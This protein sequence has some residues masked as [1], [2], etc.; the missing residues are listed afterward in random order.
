MHLIT[1]FNQATAIL[2][3]SYLIWQ[4][5]EINLASTQ[6]AI[7]AGCINFEMYEMKTADAEVV[8]SKRPFNIKKLLVCT[9]L[10]NGSIFSYTQLRQTISHYHT[11]LS[12]F[13]STNSLTKHT[14]IRRLYNLRP[15]RNNRFVISQ[16]LQNFFQ[17]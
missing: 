11:K 14:T 4:K 13:I 12:H 8:V 9:A 3:N 16:I 6:Q 10:C 2:Y 1:D 7:N 5:T 17:E 15:R